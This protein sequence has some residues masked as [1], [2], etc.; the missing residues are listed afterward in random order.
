[1]RWLYSEGFYSFL[2]WGC[3]YDLCSWCL[4]KWI[5]KDLRNKEGNIYSVVLYPLSAKILQCIFYIFRRILLV[6]NCMLIKQ[7][8]KPSW[9][10]LSTPCQCS[11]FGY[12][13]YLNSPSHSIWHNK[14]S[15]AH[16][17]PSFKT[18]YSN[19]S[20]P[21]QSLRWTCQRFVSGYVSSL[22]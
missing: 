3:G 16:F 20:T 10:L 7:S 8:T 21:F 9:L 1:M 18:M 15:W 13:T 4:L 11:S 19:L 17:F 14:L 22:Q 5:M 12:L 2:Y 6:S